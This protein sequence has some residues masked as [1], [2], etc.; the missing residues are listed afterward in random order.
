[1]NTFGI[2]REALTPS[3][4]RTEIERLRRENAVV[5]KVMTVA[6]QEDYSDVD[7]YTFLAYHALVALASTQKAYHEQLLLKQPNRLVV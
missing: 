1:M 5:H 2:P 7:R 3:D 4:M 6:D